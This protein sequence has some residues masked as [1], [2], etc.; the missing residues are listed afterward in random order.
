MRQ[1]LILVA[2]MAMLTVPFSTGCSVWRQVSRPELWGLS[3]LETWEYDRHRRSGK[4]VLESRRAARQSIAAK[5]HTMER[6][7]IDVS[8]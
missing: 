7:A 6:D 8:N 1:K 5:K 3:L 2:V 4:S